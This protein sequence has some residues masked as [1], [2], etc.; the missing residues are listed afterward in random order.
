[1]DVVEPDGIGYQDFVA[2]LQERRHGGI[3]A[4][5]DT[6]GHQNFL[7]L[8]GNVVVPLELFGNGL[9]Q[10]RRTV[11]GRVED[12]A[13]GNAVVGSLLDDLGRV[14]VRPSDLHMNDILALLL[15]LRGLLQHQTN[16]GKGQHFHAGCCLNHS[17]IAPYNGVAC[18]WDRRFCHPDSCGRLRDWILAL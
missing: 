11:V 18:P 14:E 7:R 16:L 12:I 5:T 4:L 2:G 1:M 15:Q 6:D 13:A 10:L 9:A 3:G 8:V 17:I